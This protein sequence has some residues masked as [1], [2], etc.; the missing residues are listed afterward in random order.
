MESLLICLKIRSVSLFLVSIALFLLLTPSLS[1][2]SLP[3]RKLSSLSS[4][5]NKSSYAVIFDAGSSGSRVHVF[6]FD[7]H[8]D[9]LRI[10]SDLEVFV[11]VN[12]SLSLSLSLSLSSIC[13]FLKA[14]LA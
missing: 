11:Q 5:V 7:Q 6:R 13:P 8:L 12:A 4:S 10:G 14:G 2:Q 3:N 9:L 1:T